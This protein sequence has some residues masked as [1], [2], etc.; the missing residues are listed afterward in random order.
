MTGM[1]MKGEGRQQA[2]KSLADGGDQRRYLIFEAGCWII[3]I[4]IFSE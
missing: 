3:Q 2:E 1:Q 4:G